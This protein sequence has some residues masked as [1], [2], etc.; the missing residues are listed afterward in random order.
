M[1]TTTET[2]RYL[3]SCAS[4]FW[5][6]VFEA[7]LQY[8]LQHLKPGDEILSVGCGPAIMERRLTEQGFLVVGLDVSREALACTGDAI[9]AVAAPAEEMP[10][11]DASFDVVLYI[12]S[13]QFVDN[14]RTALQR[15]AAVLRPGGRLIALLLNPASRFFRE[16][17][18]NSES[19]VRKLRHTDL[20]AIE[21]TA[22]EWFEASGEY[23]LGVDGERLFESSHHEEAALYILTC[24]KP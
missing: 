13:L 7:E 21:K 15:T 12:A 1:Q 23:Y 11:P 17:Y 4:D 24:I 10:F 20:A 9:R 8:L 14:Y 6:R 19:Y 2:E 22:S 3:K 18:A 16:R 5:Q